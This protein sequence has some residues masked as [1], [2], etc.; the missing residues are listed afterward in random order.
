ML[1]MIHMVSAGHA[2]GP[3]GIPTGQTGALQE[4]A[5]QRHVLLLGKRSR[6]TTDIHRTGRVARTAADVREWLHP[7]GTFS[8]PL[9]LQHDPTQR[10]NSLKRLDPV[11]DFL[12]QPFTCITTSYSFV[13]N[14]SLVSCNQYLVNNS[15]LY[16]SFPIILVNTGTFFNWLRYSRSFW[17]KIDLDS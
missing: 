11:H 12:A 15:A 16:M 4:R 5:V 14:V 7:T 2:E 3:Q 1:I 9:V 8:R 10:R 6:S 13:S 17:Y